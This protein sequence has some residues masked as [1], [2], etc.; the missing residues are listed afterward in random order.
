M[1]IRFSLLNDLNKL[2]V[3]CDKLSEIGHFL[4]EFGEEEDVIRMV[5]LQVKFQYVHDALLHLLNVSYVYKA[6][7]IC[8]QIEQENMCHNFIIII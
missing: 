7:T 6:R 1:C 4:E 3:L 5:G 8:A 2:S